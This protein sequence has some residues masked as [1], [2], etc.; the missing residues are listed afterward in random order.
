[1]VILQKYRSKFLSIK[2]MEK[3]L[4]F[5]IKWCKSSINHNFVGKG[6]HERYS[7]C[8]NIFHIPVFLWGYVLI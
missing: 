7:Y 1:M 8:K 2:E 3:Y 6:L 4:E 5:C